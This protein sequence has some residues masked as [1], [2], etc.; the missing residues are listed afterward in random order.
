MNEK[1]LRVKNRARVLIMIELLSLPKVTYH[2]QRS[3]F[4]GNKLVFLVFCL[5]KIPNSSFKSDLWPF[6]LGFNSTTYNLSILGHIIETMFEQNDGLIITQSM[7]SFKWYFRWCQDAA[8]KFDKI[9]MK[10]F[11]VLNLNLTSKRRI[12]FAKGIIL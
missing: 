5:V 2:S 7:L 6:G 12:L 3:I 9:M 1:G 10:C 4:K 8:S 11:I